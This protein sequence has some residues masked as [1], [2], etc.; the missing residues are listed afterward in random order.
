VELHSRTPE[1]RLSNRLRRTQPQKEMTLPRMR[2]KAY[3]SG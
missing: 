2:R 1:V 3:L